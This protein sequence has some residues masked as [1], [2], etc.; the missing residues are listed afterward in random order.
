M[1]LPSALLNA[2]LKRTHEDRDHG[3]LL[4]LMK[5]STSFFFLGGFTM[6]FIGGGCLDGG[7][8][9]APSSGRDLSSNKA[10]DPF[11]GL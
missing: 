1:R 8:P 11:P 2:T 4:G 5:G 6:M 3:L 9:F 10:L 7:L